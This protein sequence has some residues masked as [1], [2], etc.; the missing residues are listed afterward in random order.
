MTWLWF[1]PHTHTNSTILNFRPTKL[2]R[3]QSYMIVSTFWFASVII[4]F[5]LN[6]FGFA[7]GWW[8]KAKETQFKSLIFSYNFTV[9]PNF[10]YAAKNVFFHLLSF[11]LFS[12]HPSKSVVVRALFF[13]LFFIFSMRLRYLQLFLN[14][15]EIINISLKNW[16][17]LFSFS[18]FCCYFFSWN[19]VMET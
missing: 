7:F 8:T 13:F 4:S 10:V 11:L 16:L 12:F 17:H 2:N 6:D 14:L 3:A 5:K 1:N 15:H 18:L 19:C 9:F